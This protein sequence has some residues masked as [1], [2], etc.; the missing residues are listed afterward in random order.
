MRLDWLDLQLAPTALRHLDIDKMLTTVYRKLWTF[1]ER[2]RIGVSRGTL[3]DVQW[4][5]RTPLQCR[6]RTHPD[7]KAMRNNIIFFN[8][9]IFGV[10]VFLA[11]FVHIG[12]LL[13]PVTSLATS[14]IPGSAS[15]GSTNWTNPDNAT[16][17]P[18]ATRATSTTD[19]AS[20]LVLTY[21]DQSGLGTFVSAQA[22]INLQD[23][24]QTGDDDELIFKE[25]IAAGAESTLDT[26]TTA[27]DGDY[28]EDTNLF[29]ASG[30]SSWAD[31]NNASTY[32]RSLLN[33]VGG[34]DGFTWS[35]DSMFFEVTY[36]PATTYTQMG[37]NAA[38]W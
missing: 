19:A 31:L 36:T 34:D 18:D 1:R 12:F 5:G 13:V 35:V 21:G 10:F 7:K 3:I 11:A 33:K 14:N 6:F 37:D 30:L 28:T 2:R 8:S 9:F 38:N 26:F 22:A 20:L 16:G 17:L 24:G 4:N 25:R 27:T 15:T 23:D 29:Y 32:L